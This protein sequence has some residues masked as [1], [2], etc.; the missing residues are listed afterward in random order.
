MQHQS[1]SKTISAVALFCS[2]SLVSCSGGEEPT[3]KTA[4]AK[5]PVMSAEEI[6]A[7]GNVIARVGDQ[8]ISFNQINTMLNSSAV[9]GVSVPAL[10]TPQRD[11]ARIVVLDKVVSANLLYLDARRLGLDK[12]PAYVR[13][14]QE[15][16]DGMLGGQYYR[17]IMAGE[18]PVSEVEIQEFFTKTMKPGTEMSDDLH[19]QIEATIRKRKLHERVAAQRAELRQGIEVEVYPDNLAG[20]DDEAPAD[21]A[22]VAKY[23]DQVISWG[24]VKDTLVAA[25][26]GA[27]DLDLTAMEVDAQLAAL[28]MVIDKRIMAARGREAGL[29]TDAIYNSRLNEYQKTRL[30]NMHRA[31]LAEEMEPSEEQLKA[32]YEE[33]RNKIM[34]VEMR[35]LQEVLLESSEQAEQMKAKIDAGELTMFQVA[36][37]HSIAPG[38]KQQLGEVGWVAQGRAQPALDEIIFKLEPGEIGGPVESTEGWHLFKVLDVTDAKFDDFKDREA[39]KLTRRRYIHQ[40]LDDYVMALR[41]D[42]FTVDVYENNMVRLAQK[43]A[44]MVARLMEQSTVP[45][46]KTEQRV[47]E[48]NKLIGE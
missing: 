21:E 36:A 37:D 15:F 43:E 14:M 35:K 39:R 25:G 29:E 2:L 13:A 28:Q 10:G 6:A 40:Q 42:Q 3:A 38:A 30:V 32:Y 17:N 24:D 11:T 45:G 41:K 19:T 5:A 44:D 20:T 48:L 46:S 33:N 27:V 9:V 12:D 23:G 26:K 8:D 1:V 18:I 22:P 16:S 7:L 47:E 4:A 31:R 34:Q